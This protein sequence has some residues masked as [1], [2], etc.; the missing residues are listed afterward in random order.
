MSHTLVVNI[1]DEV[2]QPLAESAKRAGVEAECVA[3]AWLA[4]HSLH[5]ANDPLEG[6]I[7]AIP[8]SVADWADRH[9]D[10]LGQSLTPDDT[11]SSLGR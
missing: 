4:A 5:A 9:D 6:F 8:T 10:Y 11:S 3:A 2:Y 1:P 7:G